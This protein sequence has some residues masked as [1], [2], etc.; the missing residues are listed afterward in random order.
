MGRRKKAGNSDSLIRKFS[1]N[2]AEESVSLLN[3]IDYVPTLSKLGLNIRRHANAML[4]D[5]PEYTYVIYALLTYSTHRWASDERKKLGL[6]AGSYEMLYE[7]SE[8]ILL[9]EREVF[10]KTGIRPI[11]RSNDRYEKLLCSDELLDVI[12][13]A[14]ESLKTCPRIGQKL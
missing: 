14:A 6:D 3:K 11:L 7:L 2:R 9:R 1:F 5:H 8:N 12:E 13:E 10:K 4:S